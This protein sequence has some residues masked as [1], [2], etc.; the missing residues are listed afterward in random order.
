MMRFFVALGLV[1][2]TTSCGEDGSPEGRQ[3][4]QTSAT[5]ETSAAIST[6]STEPASFEVA[7]L[8]DSLARPVPGAALPEPREDLTV[9]GGSAVGVYFAVLTGPK[10]SPDYNVYL[11][12]NA[13]LQEADDRLRENFGGRFFGHSITN[14]DVGAVELLA[15][16]GFENVVY[17]LALHFPTVEEAEAFAAGVTPPPL[18]VGPVRTYCRD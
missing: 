15:Q 18:A 4:S 1:L 16:H 2:T 6:T 10:Y 5:T 14:C 7:P 13:R 3:A 9:H 8:L 17:Y 11:E 12:G